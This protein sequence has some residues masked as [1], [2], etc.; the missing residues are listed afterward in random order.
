MYKDVA[1]EN[2]IKI[3]ASNDNNTL[4]SA[5]RWG[6]YF[7]R[8]GQA[9]GKISPEWVSFSPGKLR[10]YVIIHRSPDSSVDQMNNTGIGRLPLENSPVTGQLVGPMPPV[11]VYLHW[12]HS[13]GGRNFTSHWIF[14]GFLTRAVL[15]TQ[16]SPGKVANIIYFT[17]EGKF[18]WDV[19]G[20]DSGRFA[21]TRVY[22]I[23]KKYANTTKK[24]TLY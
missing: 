13:R 24:L 6:P 1:S 11:W 19:T 3:Y 7:H 2:I 17:G 5:N 14:T 4:V 20:V 22:N 12:I 23:H 9:M 18:H 10:R 8:S 15:D 16:F 21:E